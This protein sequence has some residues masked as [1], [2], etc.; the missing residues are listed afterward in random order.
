MMEMKGAGRGVGEIRSD[1]PE[2]CVFVEIED[3]P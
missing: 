2:W 3:M 1:M